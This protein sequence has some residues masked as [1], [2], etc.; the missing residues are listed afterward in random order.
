M[1]KDYD[2][3]YMRKTPVYEISLQKDSYNDFVRVY[4]KSSRIKG[5]WIMRK[6]DIAGLSPQ[7]IQ[8]QF[9]L[10]YTP[11]YMC[12]VHLKAGTELRCG[13]TNGLYN[14]KGGGVQFDLYNK[15]LGTFVNERIIGGE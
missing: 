13:I 3:P 8:A 6:S 11:Q 1:A 15:R 9:A 5:G 4:N 10:P 7:E 2:P 12:D 14:R